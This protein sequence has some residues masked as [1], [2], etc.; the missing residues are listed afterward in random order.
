[1]TAAGRRPRSRVLSS[2]ERFPVASRVARATSP[3]L[4]AWHPTATTTAT[5]SVRQS[6]SLERRDEI[7]RGAEKGEMSCKK[8]LRIR[9]G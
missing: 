1:M 3:A 6:A 7:E 4:I 9:H 5:T 2:A 8:G